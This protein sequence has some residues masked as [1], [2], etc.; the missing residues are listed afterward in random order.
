VL[1][2]LEKEHCDETEKTCFWAPPKDSQKADISTDEAK[3]AI[4]PQATVDP[5]LAPFVY[6]LD[7]HSGQI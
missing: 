6:A 2:W 1:V 7:Q 4:I 5:A 3:P